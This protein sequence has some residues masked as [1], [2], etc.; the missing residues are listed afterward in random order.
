M[1]FTSGIIV[2]L[3]MVGPSSDS[4]I[5]VVFWLLPFVLGALV[6]LDGIFGTSTGIGLSFLLSRNLNV[7]FIRSLELVDSSLT[8]LNLLAASPHD[9][10]WS[11]VMLLALELYPLDSPGNRSRP[12]LVLTKSSRT[13]EFFMIE[14]ASLNGISPK[15]MP[16]Q[17]SIWSPGLKPDSLAIPFSFVN[18][19]KIPGFQSGPLQILR[20][21]SNQSNERKLIIK[22][23]LTRIPAS[24]GE[25]RLIQFEHLLALHHHDRIPSMNSMA[26]HAM[27]MDQ[28]IFWRKQKAKTN[29]WRLKQ[30]WD[31]NKSAWSHPCFFQLKRWWH[32]STGVIMSLVIKI[33]KCFSNKHQSRHKNKVQ[34]EGIVATYSLTGIIPTPKIKRDEN[35]Y[36]TIRH[37]MRGAQIDGLE[38]LGSITCKW[39]EAQ[40]GN[41]PWLIS[42]REYLRRASKQVCSRCWQFDTILTSMI[43]DKWPRDVTPQRPRAYFTPWFN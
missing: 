18:W 38:W 27:L 14:T 21:E 4:F 24:F 10:L 37:T 26:Q 29:Y 22:S 34:W 2:L 8:M 1:F 31:R 13:E 30:Q 7:P 3:I 43:N 17:L 23:K 40:S 39:P 25:L 35:Y 5:I 20:D 19:T 16:L 28:S 33:I 42:I 6:K 32:Q 12:T 9:G 11:P 41:K 36:C 15:S